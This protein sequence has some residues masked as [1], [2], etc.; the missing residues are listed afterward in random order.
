MRNSKKILSLSLAAT[1][2]AST[3]TVFAMPTDTVII[4]NEAFD[5]QGLGT[6]KLDAEVEAAIKDAD[7]IYYNIDGVTN[8]L[9]LDASDDSKMTEVEEK[10]LV[11]ISLTNEDGLKV[12]L[13][14]FSDDKGVATVATKEEL[15]A[16]VNNGY[17]GVVKLAGDIELEAEKVAVKR[18]VNIDLAGHTLKGNVDVVAAEGG[19]MEILGLKDS[20]L[21]GALTID[22]GKA[23][24]KVAA[25]VTI[26][27]KTTIKDVKSSTFINKGTLK[28]VV[29]EDPNGSGFQND[30][31]VETIAIHTAAKVT[32]K[33]EKEIPKVIVDVEDAEVTLEVN[34]ATVEADKPFKIVKESNIKV[35][36]LEGEGV[37]KIHI[38]DA[39]GHELDPTKVIDI[40]KPGPVTPDK[41]VVPPHTGGGGTV[42][43]PVTDTVAPVIAGITNGAKIKLTD[44]VT[45]VRPTSADKDIKT[46]A[47]TKDGTVVSEYTT[48]GDITEAGSYVL[49]VTDNAGNATTI[50]FT[51]L[52][53]EAPV[54]PTEF[55]VNFAENLTDVAELTV[56]AIELKQVTL[57]VDNPGKDVTLAVYSDEKS[58]TEFVYDNAGWTSKENPTMNPTG[59]LV[60]NFD[61]TISSMTVKGLEQVKVNSVDIAAKSDVT[62]RVDKAEK[63][64]TDYVYESGMGWDKGT[65]VDKAKEAAI[66]KIAGYV[67]AKDASDL[68][69]DE[70]IVAGAREI[71]AKEEYLSEYKEFV[72]SIKDSDE[73]KEN[74]ASQYAAIIACNGYRE[75][76]WKQVQKDFK[77]EN[78]VISVNDKDGNLTV[79]EFKG[80]L[81]ALNTRLVFKVI[82]TSELSSEPI[83]EIADT[84][85]LTSDMYLYV[86]YVIEGNL[87][88]SFVDEI[89]VIDLS[90]KPDPSEFTIS[91]DETASSVLATATDI[92]KITV[93]LANVAD[94]VTF[95][96]YEGTGNDNVTQFVY[97]TAD[98][99]SSTGLSDKVNLDDLSISF[100]GTVTQARV[101]E[102][103]N[104]QIN[105]VTIESQL[106][107]NVTSAV[108][109]EAGTTVTKVVYKNN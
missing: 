17:A 36:K 105:S 74:D 103:A 69:I 76:A 5:L 3:T 75:Y 91:F 106:A 29:I 12:V 56:K 40:V 35:H 107:E 94:N 30:G 6:D 1:M 83:V 71:D 32:L 20:K 24:F 27:G 16:Q 73:F 60:V 72:S 43:P 2:L 19:E 10:K 86:S 44:D 9:F 11:N 61:P 70:L 47:L 64:V 4:G 28:E 42:T 62:V 34:V 87:E 92:D 68:T 66:D 18:L 78:C 41:P 85:K 108:Y 93:G 22:T 49:T 82:T 95:S 104:T 38:E 101:V 21:D 100:D 57:N 26:E 50:N 102:G 109:D 8:G 59:G 14:D 39:A 79:G 7:A 88:T 31:A 52:A 13:A 96:V 97:H 48:L 46:I 81:N 33:G 58:I 45:K 80:K 89:K 98:G 37:A 25:N 51:I 90:V 55:T 99:W 54:T 23:D 15:L 84:E 63:T 67:S 53:K 65:E 77:V